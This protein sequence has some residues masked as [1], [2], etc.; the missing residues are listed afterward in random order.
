L[1]RVITSE[2]ALQRCTGYI[3]AT[4]EIGLLLSD[5][6]DLYHRSVSGTEHSCA[7]LPSQGHYII[8]IIIIEA[9]I[10]ELLL[11]ALHLNNNLP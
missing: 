10:I 2:E 5:N 11:V 7:T 6:P 9:D 4:P 1:H 8:I 3:L